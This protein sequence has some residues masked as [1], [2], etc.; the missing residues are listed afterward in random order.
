MKP[1]DKVPARGDEEASLF[2]DEVQ[3]VEPLPVVDKVIHSRKLPRPTINRVLRDEA[4]IL[5]SSFPDHNLPEMETG[6][7]GSFLRSG[8]S[9]QT[10]RR[11]RR[12]YWKIN[13]RLDLHGFTRDEAQQELGEF[14]NT[15][16]DRGFRCVQVIHGKGLNSKNHE[17]ILKTMVGNWLAQHNYVLAFCQANPADGGSGAALV[18]LKTATSK[19][20]K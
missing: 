9:R 20:K 19:R 8:V 5:D 1:R 17:P 16:Q 15:C 12:G 7:E 4:S 14:F 6:D 3:D 13:A 18:L 2:R 11:L 10:M